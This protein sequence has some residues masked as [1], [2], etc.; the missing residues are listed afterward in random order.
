MF[1]GTMDTNRTT[2]VNVIYIYVKARK[3][4]FAQDK[5][6]SFIISIKNFMGLLQAA[7]ML[8]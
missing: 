6:F 3:Y 7:I 1:T 8:P 2:I 5:L 4:I